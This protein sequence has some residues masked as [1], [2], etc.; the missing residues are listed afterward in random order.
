MTEKGWEYNTAKKEIILHDIKCL[1]LAVRMMFSGIEKRHVQKTL[2]L[3]KDPLAWSKVCDIIEKRYNDGSHY[4]KDEHGRF[5]GSTSSGGS[6]NLKLAD[7]QIYRSVGAKAKNY[8]VMDLTTGEKFH[9]VEGTRLQNVEVF[10]GKGVKT[11]YRNAWK[12][13]R[14]FGGNEKD[15]QHV[16]AKGT[17]DFYGESRDAEVHWSQCAGIGKFDFFIK[18]WLE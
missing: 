2:S 8:D 16:K 6:G 4:T 7:I 12:Y 9:F 10:A 13:A 15:W 14:D 17:L 5:T 1:K 18:R 11:P 3:I